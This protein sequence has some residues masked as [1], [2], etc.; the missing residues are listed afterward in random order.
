[1]TGGLRVP[2]LT[3]NDERVECRLIYSLRQRSVG[4]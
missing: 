2:G 1:M 4:V 3:T